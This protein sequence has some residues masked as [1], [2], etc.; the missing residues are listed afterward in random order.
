MLIDKVTVSFEIEYQ[1][2]GWSCMS[3][4]I[5]DSNFW[6]FLLQAFILGMPF[7][8][9]FLAYRWARA[10]QKDKLIERELRQLGVQNTAVSDE[11]ASHRYSMR[12]YVWPVFSASLLIIVI[13]SM[14]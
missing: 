2:E 9:A 4:L 6:L 1:R 3:S 13:F 14:T 10:P 7:P 11:L 12:D 8:A 5:S